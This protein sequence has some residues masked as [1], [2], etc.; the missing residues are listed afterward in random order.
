MVKSTKNGFILSEEE[1]ENLEKQNINGSIY[2]VL[3]AKKKDFD[4][5]ILESLI[6][7][8]YNKVSIVEYFNTTVY[9]LNNFLEENYR[10][11]RIEDIDLKLKEQLKN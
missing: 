5:K 2:Y 7:K 4:N 3:V 9:K 10:T 1:Y 11:K 8:G 6:L